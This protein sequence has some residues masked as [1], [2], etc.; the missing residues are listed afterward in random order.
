MCGK[1]SVASPI[2]CATWDI[3]RFRSQR[4]RRWLRLGAQN[5]SPEVETTSLV[6]GKQTGATIAPA[7]HAKDLPIVVWRKMATNT[8]L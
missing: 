7:I 1:S 8:M 5:I 3:P 6:Q 4:R 2:F